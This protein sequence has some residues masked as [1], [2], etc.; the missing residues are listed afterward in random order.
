[1]NHN[2]GSDITTIDAWGEYP[3]G[4]STIGGLA[5]KN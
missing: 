1:M 2:G 3:T 4:F 5:R